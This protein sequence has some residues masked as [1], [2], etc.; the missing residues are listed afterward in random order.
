MNTCSHHAR[1]GLLFS[2]RFLCDLRLG[3]DRSKRARDQ[4]ERARPD[5]WCSDPVP[6]EHQRAGFHVHT[7]RDVLLCSQGLAW[8][9]GSR[10]N[11]RANSCKAAQSGV[12]SSL[13]YHV[14]PAASFTCTTLERN[15]SA[16]AEERPSS[17][18]VGKWLVQTIM[19][20]W[21]THSW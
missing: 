4:I 6:T 9:S 3:R 14:C 20:I 17:T 13:M 19:A 18:D 11:H 8:R 12:T 15:H 10:W 7:I 5:R 16:S 21:Y 1:E 2:S